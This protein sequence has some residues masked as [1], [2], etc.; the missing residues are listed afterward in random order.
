MSR[1]G[2]RTTVAMI[3]MNEAEAV[4]KVI[5]DIRRAVADAE[6]LI[7]DSSRDFHAGDRTLARR[8]CRQAVSAH[9]LWPGHGFGVAVE[10]ARGGGDP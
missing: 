4:A 9:G 6:I 8:A 7:V 5:G 2:A 1:F 10:R 3:T